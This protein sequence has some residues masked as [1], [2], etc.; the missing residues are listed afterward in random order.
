[1]GPLE[2]ASAG[3]KDG[4]SYL[5][6]CGY[7]SPNGKGQ[8]TNVV[9]DISIPETITVVYGTNRSRFWA[10]KHQH[11]LTVRTNGKPKKSKDTWLVV[12]VNAKANKVTADLLSRTEFFRKYE[13]Y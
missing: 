7:L 11:T 6:D 4:E 13:N 1:M 3:I 5:T 2:I 10:E 9:M 8:A 12:E